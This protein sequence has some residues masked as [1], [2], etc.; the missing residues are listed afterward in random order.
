MNL[1]VQ[2]FRYH[3]Q[4][5]KLN[6]AI[7]G[8]ISDSSVQ[9]LVDTGASISVL[10]NRLATFTERDVTTT[11]NTECESSEQVDHF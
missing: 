11:E 8:T 7:T 2:N 5:I 6:L 9:V 4:G 3:F 10:S 1:T